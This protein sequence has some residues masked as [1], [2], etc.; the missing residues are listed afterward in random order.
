VKNFVALQ[1]IAQFQL[2]RHEDALRLAMTALGAR[3]QR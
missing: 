1:P 2:S 3:K